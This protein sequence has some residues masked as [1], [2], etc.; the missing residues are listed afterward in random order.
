MKIDLKAT[1]ARSLLI[2]LFVLILL[3]AGAGF[4]AGLSIVRESAIEV[5]HAS[6]DASAGN[7]QVAGLQ[8]LQKQLEQTQMLV[9]KADTMFAPAADYQRSVLTDLGVYA[10]AAGITIVNTEFGEATPAPDSATG[11]T[12]P[13]TI[14]LAQ[15]VSYVSLLRF[16]QLTEGSLPKITVTGVSIGNIGGDRINVDP[17]TLRIS[18]K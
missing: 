7:N 15:P 6:E 4:Y 10:A 5:T 8:A 9:Q 12:R 3:G 1:T 11:E 2:V 13:V 18:V 16:L 14:T 17:I